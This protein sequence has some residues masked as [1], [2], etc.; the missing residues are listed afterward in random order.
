M[1]GDTDGYLI[2]NLKQMIANTHVEVYAIQPTNKFIDSSKV[3]YEL[4]FSITQNFL[5]KYKKFLS[6]FIIMTICY[7]VFKF[8]LVQNILFQFIKRKKI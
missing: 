1:V 8:D 7:M 4:A 6:R 5:L 3:T 2:R